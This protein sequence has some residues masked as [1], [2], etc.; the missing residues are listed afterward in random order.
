[1]K[2]RKHPQNK[3]S[4]PEAGVKRCRVHQVLSWVLLHRVIEHIEIIWRGAVLQ[5]PEERGAL[6][7]VDK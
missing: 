1:M 6:S 4:L 3:I 2:N 5:K 7:R